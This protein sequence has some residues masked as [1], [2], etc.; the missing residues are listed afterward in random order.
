MADFIIGARGA[1]AGG[2]SNAGS[3]Y[4]YSGADGSLLYQKDG[5]YTGYYLG[6]SVA[7]A[8]DANGD[9]KDDFI[10]AAWQAGGMGLAYVYSGADGSL[11]FGKGGGGTGL[12]SLEVAG[13]GDVN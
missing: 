11:L 5:D 6:A 9:G 10:I 1:D 12:F 3:A 13:A 8:G 7:G 2:Q 4:V